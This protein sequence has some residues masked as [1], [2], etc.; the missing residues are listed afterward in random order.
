MGAAKGVAVG[1]AMA[2]SNQFLRGEPVVEFDA[3]QTAAVDPEVV[4]RLLN[5]GLARFR[6]GLGRRWV[7]HGRAGGRWDGT[8]LAAAG[9]T[10][11]AR[12]G[13]GCAY[14]VLAVILPVQ[15]MREP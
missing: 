13:H 1:M 2:M 5:F 12:V 9:W 4:G 14:L 7:V 8:S 10:G 15:E 6:D 11:S 3:F